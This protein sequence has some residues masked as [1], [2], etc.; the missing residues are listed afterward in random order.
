L[1]LL[2]L[3]RIGKAFAQMTEIIVGEAETAETL[4]R[5]AREAETARIW[6]AAP[7]D[8]ADRQGTSAPLARELTRFEA[9]ALAGKP[10]LVV[11]A[12]DSDVALAAALVAT[13]LL[14][15]VV[16]VEGAM[17]PSSANGRLIAQLADAYTR[18]A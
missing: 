16:A 3:D 9:A 15:P 13:K 1:S 12:D 5:S 18:A 11:L 4:A 7:P 10:E 8:P 2:F 17:S 14:I 6:A